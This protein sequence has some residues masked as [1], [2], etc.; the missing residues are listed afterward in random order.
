MSAVYVYAVVGPTDYEEVGLCG[1]FLTAPEADRAV[2]RASEFYGV[3]D[4]PSQYRVIEVRV[5]ELLLEDL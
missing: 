5:G 2:T 1:V 3:D 4:V